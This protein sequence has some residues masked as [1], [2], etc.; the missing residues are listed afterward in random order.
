MKSIVSVSL[1]SSARDYRFTT[2]ILG[3]SVQVERIG[4]NGDTARAAELIRSLD[5]K[6]DAIG[7][8]GL[9]PVFRVGRARY[10]HHEAIQIAAQARRTPVVDGGVVK[11][12][13]ERWVV[14]QAQRK[15][16]QLFR[17][18]RVLLTSGIERYQLASAISQ[19]D[20]EL[21]FADPLVHFG[22]SFLPVP[23]TLGQLELYAAT[24]LPI[25]ALLPS[26]Y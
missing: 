6:V 16:P 24:T 20:A 17:Y 4:T 5:G 22:L 25:T 19:Y 8:G 2:T 23:R 7:L 3:R 9:T 12:T 26:D 13:L 18:R 10:P 1:G 15:L 14:A 11:A 21:R